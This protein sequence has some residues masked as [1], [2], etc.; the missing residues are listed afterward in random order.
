M[1]WEGKSDELIADLRGESD[2]VGHPEKADTNSSPRVIL[3]RDAYSYFPNNREAIDY[4]TFRSK[5]WPLGSGV[6]EGA[7][8]QFNLRMKG[9]DKSWNVSNMG[10]EEMLALCAH[11]HSEDGRWDRYWKSRAQPR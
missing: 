5:G 8:K 6:T 1:L 3:Y 10:A 11:Y 4:P 9:S 2:R 7:V